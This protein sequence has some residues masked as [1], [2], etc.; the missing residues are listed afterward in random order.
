MQ[1]AGTCLHCVL[2]KV[3]RAEMGT[4]PAPEPV[5]QLRYAEPLMLPVSS[6]TIYRALRRLVRAARRVPGAGRIRLEVLDGPGRAQVEVIATVVHQRSAA[7]LSCHF[8]RHAA[9]TLDG[10]FVEGV[11]TLP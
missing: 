7:V 4:G 10:G 11:E 5:V 8:D 2:E 9:G 3:L 6:A 1:R